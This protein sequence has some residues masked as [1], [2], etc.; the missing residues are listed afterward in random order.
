MRRRLIP[1]L[2]RVLLTQT[3]VDRP[4]AIAALKDKMNLGEDWALYPDGASFYFVAEANPADILA[5]E[6]SRKDSLALALDD[7]LLIQAVAQLD[8]EERQKL[9]VKPGQGLRTA[10]ECKQRVR[11][12]YRSL[13]DSQ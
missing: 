12:I 11:A 4:A 7:N 3:L 8:F 9:Q 2:D 6:T 5:L 1:D 13:L 10:A